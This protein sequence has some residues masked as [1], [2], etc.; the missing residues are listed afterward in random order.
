M[1][2]GIL[3]DLDE[4]L[5]NRKKS[6]ES[7]IRDQYNRYEPYLARVEGDTYCSRFIELDN[8]G[9]TWKDR[10]YERLVD[11]YQFPLS[12]A[13]LL[14]DYL[15]YFKQ[16]CHPFPGMFEMLEALKKRGYKLGII[17]NG[18]TEF[19]LSNIRALGI[20]AYFDTIVISEEEEVKKP[21]STIFQ[22]AL[23]RMNIKAHEAIFVGDHLINDVKGAKEVGMR[24]V[25]KK[26]EEET[27]ETEEV[28]IYSLLD[29]LSVVE[30]WTEKTNITRY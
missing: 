23:E 25:W 2:K 22:R 24:A 12:S 3:F 10:V 5:L 1:I 8:N 18:R 16:H 4:T 13:E 29:L 20:E 27:E 14:D 17:T 26:R 30:E 7:F 28:S 21:E 15:L 19:Q 6:V 9:Y 11:E